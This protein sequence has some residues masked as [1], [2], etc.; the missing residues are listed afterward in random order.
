MES[1]TRRR[2]L[3]LTVL[4]PRVSHRDGS[5]RGGSWSAARVGRRRESV[6][7]GGWW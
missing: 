3:W 5:V 1:I 4:T 7:G 6:G 2:T